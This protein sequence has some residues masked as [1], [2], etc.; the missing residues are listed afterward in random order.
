V[1]RFR[2]VREEPH[3]PSPNYTEKA[4]LVLTIDKRTVARK[5]NWHG[6]ALAT[7]YGAP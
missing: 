3:V 2:V 6:V 1:K 4:Q 5:R 7:K